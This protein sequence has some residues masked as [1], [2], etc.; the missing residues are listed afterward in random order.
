MKIILKYN[1]VSFLSVCTC[2]LFSLSSVLPESV[3]FFD[4]FFLQLYW[5]LSQSFR[6]QRHHLSMCQLA[7][8]PSEFIYGLRALL[9]LSKVTFHVTCGFVSLSVMKDE[10]IN[11]TKL[12]VREYHCNTLDCS[13]LLFS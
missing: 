8:L 11:I 13:L 6:F 3:T 12:T 1:F 10:S 2:L 7:G 5:R 4:L 9:C